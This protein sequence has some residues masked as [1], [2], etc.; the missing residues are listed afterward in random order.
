MGNAIKIIED[1]P[2]VSKLKN[3]WSEYSPYKFHPQDQKYIQANNLDK[4]CLD[5]SIDRMKQEYGEHFE[6][7]DKDKFG[8]G[9]IPNLY[10]VPFFGNVLEAKAYILTLNPH[11]VPACFHEDYE[12]ELHIQRLEK[13][14][15]LIMKT[16]FNIDKKLAD[17][18]GYRY[19]HPKYKSIIHNVAKKSDLNWEET[20][21]RVT[22]NVAVI[23]SIAYHSNFSPN[24]WKLFPL[25]SSQLAKEFVNQYLLPKVEDK[26][27]F[28][29][30][31][32]SA[33]HWGLEDNG[34]NLIVRD[35]TKAISPIST[36]ETSKIADFLIEA[37]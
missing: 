16:P 32:R 1:T 18:G 6:H 10:P 30:V 4:Y 14:L 15:K 2:I 26:K 20:E 21:K 34:S 33:R 8:N 35:S 11:F 29:F 3:F 22:E 9:I 27:A 37:F 36:E 7:Y 23:E 12:N 31:H 28:I 24:V 13:N 5:V 17:T 25:P 19:W